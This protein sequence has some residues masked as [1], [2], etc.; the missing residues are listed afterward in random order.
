M[1][2]HGPVDNAGPDHVLHSL[3]KAPSATS[4]DAACGNDD[5]MVIFIALRNIEADAMAV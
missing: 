3:P 4:W 2:A 5:V 1:L